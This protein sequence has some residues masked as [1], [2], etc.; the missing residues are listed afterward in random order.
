MESAENTKLGAWANKTPAIILNIQRQ[1][2]ANVIQVVD[3]IKKLLPKL[4]STL[5][6]SLD[7]QML[8]DRTTTIRASVEDV[9]FELGLAVVLV[10]AVIY[11]FLR[12]APATFIPAMAV[13]L[14]LVGTLGVMYLSGFSINNLTLMALTIATG[15]VVDDAIVMIENISRYIEEGDEPMEAT[16]KGAG[17]IGFTII[18]LTFSLIAVLIPL[19]FMGDVVGRLFHEF[20]ITLAVA[21]LISAFV[22]LTFTPMLCA[23][24]L[25]HVPEEEQGRFYHT[26][27]TFFDNI[28]AHYGAMLKWVLR[29]QR[30][31]LI[32]AVGTLVFTVV[33]YVYIPKGFFPVQDTGA[34]QVITQAPE[35]VSYQEMATRQNAVAEEI[36]KDPAVESLSSFIGVD[37]TNSTLNSGRML[38]NLV[39]H[40]KRDSAS[41]V[42]RRLNGKFANN[43][44]MG[45][46]MQPVQDLTIEDRVSRTQYQFSVEDT[47]PKELSEWVPKLVDRLSKLPQLAD[48]ASDLQ[49]HGLAAYID[50]DRATAM[51]LGVTVAAI[52]NTIY[53]AFG[54]R[55]VST[56]YGQANQYRVVLEGEARLRTG[57]GVA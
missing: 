50:I 57:A 23:R 55:Q 12:S 18:S 42:I 24:L 38:V 9:E 8:T 31:T 26:M 45:V 4:Q 7:I 36:L 5:P 41:D 44:A 30:A 1:P 34:I 21:I 3:R 20:A 51:R 10:V 6:G 37:G 40:G 15:F 54:Q 17:Q 11:F 48:V 2:G 52:D 32:V 25:K 43:S 19:L 29:R 47:N 56:I 13:P 27:G 22:S 16:L 53:D 33:L 14:S 35:T 28:I 46:Y 49:D 39:P